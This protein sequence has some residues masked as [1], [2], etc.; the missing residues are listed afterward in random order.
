MSFNI[1]ISDF[2]R[3]PVVCIGPEILMFVF[4]PDI[5]LMLLKDSSRHNTY[6]LLLTVSST[7][8]I[9]RTDLLSLYARLHSRIS[10]SPREVGPRVPGCL[11]TYVY[12][13]FYFPSSPVP[14][15]VNDL[16]SLPV[17]F[18]SFNVLVVRYSRLFISTF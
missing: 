15:P 5:F 10:V 18:M 8:Y 9:F 12:R 1:L 14:F 16:S 11:C 2:T 13:F 6:Y 17:Y 7:V 4:L 3:V